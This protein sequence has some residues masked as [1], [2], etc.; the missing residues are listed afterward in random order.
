MG[1]ELSVCSNDPSHMN[2]MVATNEKILK[3]HLQ[4]YI[5]FFLCSV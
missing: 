2:K 5:K 3:N 1:E 4:K